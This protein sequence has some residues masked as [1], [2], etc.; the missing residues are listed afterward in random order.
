MALTGSM[1]SRQRMRAARGEAA[2]NALRLA[3]PNLDRDIRS[4][5][6][7]ARHLLIHCRHKNTTGEQTYV[8][9]RHSGGGMLGQM[10]HNSGRS[11]L[12]T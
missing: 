6:L 3:R 1:L 11:S 4:E 7:H 5:V 8:R 2:W 12:I 10:F 9:D